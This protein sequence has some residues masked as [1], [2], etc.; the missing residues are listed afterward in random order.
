[1]LVLQMMGCRKD[2]FNLNYKQAC[3]TSG[4]PLSGFMIQVFKI[5]HDARG[6]YKRRR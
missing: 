3:Q 2:Y 1:M 5:A 4:L 6:C